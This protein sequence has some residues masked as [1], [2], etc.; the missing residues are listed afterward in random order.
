LHNHS[1]IFRDLKPENVAYGLRHS[2][3]YAIVWFW[4][5]QG[6]D[7]KRFGATTGWLQLYRL[8]GLSSVHG[9]RSH[10]HRIK[11]CNSNNITN[12]N[13]KF[14]NYKYHL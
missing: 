9:A 2:W 7:E 5:G 10:G 14:V 3:G 13:H 8:D 11:T 6:I 4:I 12:C 1:I